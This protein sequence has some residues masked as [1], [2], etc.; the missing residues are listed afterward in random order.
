[1]LISEVDDPAISSISASKWH[2][3]GMDAWVTTVRTFLR[4]SGIGGIPWLLR[5]WIGASFGLQ[6]VLHVN[7]VRLIN[8]FFALGN[9]WLAGKITNS[10]IT[11]HDYFPAEGGNSLAE[12]AIASGGRNLAL[13]T[14]RLSDATLATSSAGVQVACSSTSAD[15]LSTGNWGRRG[16]IGQL[17]NGR[18]WRSELPPY[19]YAVDK[20]YL[21]AQIFSTN[22]FH[23]VTEVLPVVIRD[24][25]LITGDQ[26]RRVIASKASFV[27]D[28]LA[29]AGIPNKVI[30]TEDPS[31]LRVRDLIAPRM[32]PWGFMS[33]P[34][35]QEVRERILRSVPQG[36][37]PQGSLPR[38]V[39]LARE[40]SNTRRISN[41]AEVLDAV[42][43][44][45]PDMTYVVPG[46]LSVSDQVQV[47]A[48]ADVIIAPHGAQATNLIWSRSLA[49][50]IEIVS[51]ETANAS[52]SALAQACGAQVSCVTAHTVGEVH[53]HSDVTV[54]LRSLERALSA[55]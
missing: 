19:P 7:E 13:V 3:R 45:Y 11:A 12:S 1:M 2:Y 48:G 26:E 8:S 49:H 27:E 15:E 31:V 4:S 38:I 14:M 23:F 36:S 30:L 53:H 43:A 9:W 28:L 18:S 35:L 39:Y 32:L 10:G 40:A 41:E 47:C 42:L 21:G 55:I 22:Y 16:P 5:T 54:D 34:L 46:Q 24:R 6:R 25:D 51:D 33:A 17:L 52:L 29:L 44:R 20:G 50:F 37:V